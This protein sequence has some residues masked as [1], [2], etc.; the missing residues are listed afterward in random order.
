MDGGIRNVSPLGDVI[1]D[2]N[3]IQNFEYDTIRQFYHDWYRTDLQA[4]AIVGDAV[5]HRRGRLGAP[6]RLFTPDMEEARASVRRIATLDFEVCCFGHGP[7]LVGNAAQR[8]RAFA[9][10]L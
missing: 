2:L 7:P 8:V 9:E 10:S 1:G 3:V 6:P 5:N 4:I